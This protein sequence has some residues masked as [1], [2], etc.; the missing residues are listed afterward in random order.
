VLS[1]IVC[2]LVLFGFLFVSA[3]LLLTFSCECHLYAVDFANEW[4]LR[5]IN[6]FEQQFLSLSLF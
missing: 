2:L 6:R 4:I 3:L 1:A 5:V